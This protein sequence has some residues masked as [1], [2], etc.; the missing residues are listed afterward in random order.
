MVA[1]LDEF[2]ALCRNH[3]LRKLNII[4]LLTKT[5]LLRHKLESGVKVRDHL[6][7]GV[8][9][10]NSAKVATKYFEELI[11]GKFEAANVQRL[12]AKSQTARDRQL[13]VFAVNLLQQ[14][15]ARQV[16]KDARAFVAEKD[17]V[18]VLW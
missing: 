14:T 6:T 8:H 9:R 3:E 17:I 18:Q 2:G 10:E 5:D 15:E 4:V 16:I 7:Y 12:Q 13:R 11:Q 1:A